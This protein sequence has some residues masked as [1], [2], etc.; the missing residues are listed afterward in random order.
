MEEDM[1]SLLETLSGQLLGG[2]T[3][4]Q[5]SR[6]IGADE[7]ATTKALAG[8][9]PI[10]LGG[11]A[12]NSSRSQGASSL[13]SALDRDHDGSVLD[14][15]GGFLQGG[16]SASGAGILGHVFGGRQPAVEQSLSRSSGLSGAQVSQLLAMVAPLVMGFLGR[17]K[18]S[19]GF[20][21]GQLASMLGGERDEMARRQPKAMGAL[22]GL[23]DSDGDGSIMDDVADLGGSLLGGFLKGNR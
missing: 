19:Q 4:G 7:G 5:L 13:A 20:D 16:A 6:T 22:A 15:I 8:A 10:L 12:G 9:L 11:L 23:L 17:E 1:S 21:A 18:R 2:D 3:V 14:D